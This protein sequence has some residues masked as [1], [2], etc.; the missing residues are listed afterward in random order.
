MI[1]ISKE[2]ALKIDW[3][4]FLVFCNLHYKLSLKIVQYNIVS[5]NSK[6]NSEPQNQLISYE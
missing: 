4:Q 6:G 5:A 3:S 2:V 1:C